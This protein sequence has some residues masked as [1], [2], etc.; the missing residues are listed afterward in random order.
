MT[1]RLDGG[2]AFPGM[3]EHERMN[4]HIGRYETFVMPTGGMTLRDYFAAKALP[5]AIRHHLEVRASTI[6]PGAFDF[7][8][9]SLTA[10]KQA[11]SMLKERA[12]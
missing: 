11:D 7:D 1:T 8:L 12:K 5:E 6:D 3:Q 10:Y 2:P 4:D 9:V